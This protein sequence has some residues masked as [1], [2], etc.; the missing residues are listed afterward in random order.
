MNNIELNLIHDK[1]V[2]KIIKIS[3]GTIVIG[4]WHNRL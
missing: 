1:F 4:I 2:V 3:F